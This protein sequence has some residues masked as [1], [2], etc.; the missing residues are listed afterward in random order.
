M[1]NISISL[2]YCSFVIFPVFSFFPNFNSSVK[3]SCSFSISLCFALCLAAYFFS[4]K[5]NQKI[6]WLR[7]FFPLCSFSALSRF[8]CLKASSC[9][10]F[11]NVISSFTLYWSFLFSSLNSSSSHLFYSSSVPIFQLPFQ[12]LN[13]LIF[14][15]ANKKK[16]FAVS[17]GSK[18]LNLNILPSYRNK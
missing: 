5:P 9:S 2:L 1:S 13:S 11:L 6:T 8:A 17:N 14:G 18:S 4:K 12:S 15:I 10:L 3:V 16:D 7:T